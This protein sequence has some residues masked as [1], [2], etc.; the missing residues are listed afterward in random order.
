MTKKVFLQ[1][2]FKQIVLFYIRII[3]G[4]G[5]LGVEQCLYVQFL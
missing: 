3:V 2:P 5:L 1:N 4:F